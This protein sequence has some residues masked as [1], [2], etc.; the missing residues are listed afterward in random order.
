MGVRLYVGDLVQISQN[1]SYTILYTDMPDG[2]G[3]PVPVTICAAKCGRWFRKISEDIYD[4]FCY[5]CYRE[6]FEGEEDRP[7]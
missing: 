3:Y 1:K 5:V 4:G 2:Y 7:L 6:Q